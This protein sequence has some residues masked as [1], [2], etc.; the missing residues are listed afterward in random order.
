[1]S[2]SA[3][4]KYHI[5]VKPSNDLVGVGGGKGSKLIVGRRY[6]DCVLYF[7]KTEETGATE[8]QNTVGVAHEKA[9]VC[10]S[11]IKKCVCPKSLL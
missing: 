11:K 5:D 2:C 10:F 3:R 6:A 7:W 8:V 1:M 4:T 9:T